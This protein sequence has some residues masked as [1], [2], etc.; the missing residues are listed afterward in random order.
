[1]TARQGEGTQVDDRLDPLQDEIDRILSQGPVG[2][3]SNPP[4]DFPFLSETVVFNVDGSGTMTSWSAMSGKT[5]QAFTWSMGAPGRLVIR[6]GLT[7]YAAHLDEEPKAEEGAVELSPI[8]HDIEIKVQETHLGPWPVMTSEGRDTFD[9][10]WTALAR[11]D[12][13]LVLQQI[14]R[15]L[16]ADLPAAHLP[17]RRSILS[18]MF[19]WMRSSREDPVRRSA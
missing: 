19:S 10:L 5:V 14:A 16:P 4:P 8:T 7:R 2:L 1:L 6:Y 15:D 17:P 9:Y 11:N 13:P 12:P 3:W 18:W